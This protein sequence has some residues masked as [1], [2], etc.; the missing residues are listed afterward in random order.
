MTS[1]APRGAH[2]S[3]ANNDRP[4]RFPG[5][6]RPSSFHADL[7]LLPPKQIS[8]FF[9]PATL[10]N[11]RRGEPFAKWRINR[12]AS[13][14][15]R[16]ARNYSLAHAIFTSTRPARVASPPGNNR[17]VI[18]DAIIISVVFSP[19]LHVST[20]KVK[21]CVPRRRSQLMFLFVESR[22][23]QTTKFMTPLSAFRYSARPLD[24]T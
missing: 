9:L 15:S 11:R 20:S 6:R 2:L 8:P 19:L 5:C 16:R 4:R 18:I 12:V 23:D 21:I 3:S 24:I 7:L 13:I 22:R 10:L 17:D 1:N 14:S